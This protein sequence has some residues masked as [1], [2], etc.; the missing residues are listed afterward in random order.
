[1]GLFRFVV[2]QKC[3]KAI[4]VTAP[5]HFKRKM[6]ETSG[7]EKPNVKKLKWEGKINV[8]NNLCDRREAS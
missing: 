4:N 3:D 8:V 5:L 2:T 7:K 1:M 6:K